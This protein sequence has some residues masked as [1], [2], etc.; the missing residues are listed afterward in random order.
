[1]SIDNIVVCHKTC[2]SSTAK[3]TLIWLSR[4][5]DQSLC[6][7]GYMGI[8]DVLVVSG[9]G[10][11]GTIFKQ[12]LS[13]VGALGHNL[14]RT[15]Q[16]HAGLAAMTDFSQ[17]ASQLSQRAAVCSYLWKC[18]SM[19]YVTSTNALLISQLIKKSTLSVGYLNLNLK[20]NMWKTRKL[21]L[22]A[23]KVD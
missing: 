23:V 22:R 4:V 11:D 13:K 1:M 12:F 16:S 3:V 19:E 7:W 9:F 2:K 15:F 18:R 10:S 8:V 5:W 17:S 6:Q 14:P 20:C 21:D